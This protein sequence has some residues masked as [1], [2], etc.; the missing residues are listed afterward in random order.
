MAQYQHTPL[1][2]DMTEKIFF[3][4]F[5]KNNT[6]YEIDVCKKF[7]GNTA[8]DKGKFKNPNRMFYSDDRSAFMR[9]HGLMKWILFKLPQL[10]KVWMQ[11]GNGYFASTVV[12]YIFSKFKSSMVESKGY[13]S[14]FYSESE[15]KLMMNKKL[16]DVIK[17]FNKKLEMN[18][19]RGAIDVRRGKRVL[20]NYKLCKRTFKDLVATESTGLNHLE[21]LVLSLETDNFLV[22]YNYELNRNFIKELYE[23]SFDK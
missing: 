23:E 19:N 14:S 20:G 18:V 21:S 8:L 6:S 17:S 16:N 10:L 15:K 12:G 11:S 22:S 9:K 7:F 13:S 3:F 2:E 5:K 1:P 4:F